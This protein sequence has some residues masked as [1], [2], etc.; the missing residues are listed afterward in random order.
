VN[1]VPCRSATRR[2]REPGRLRRT[3]TFGRLLGAVLIAGAAW[4][5]GWLTDS[6]DFALDPD[7]V[8]YAGLLRTPIDEVRAAI[9]IAAE[10]RPNVFGL[11]TA[12]MERRLAGLPTVAGARVAVRLPDGLDVTLVER[13]PVFQLALSGGTFLVGGDG[14]LL[15]PA[16]ASGASGDELLP[17]V[18]DNRAASRPLRP[19]DRLDEIDL[20]AITNLAAVG[21]AEL[22]SAA[23][24]LRLSIDDQLGFAIS[25]E[26]AGW[27]AVFGFYT[28]H[29]R[30]TAIIARQ[31]QCLRSLLADGEESVDTVYLE[32]TA[33][34]CG[35]FRPRET[36]S[37]EPS[38]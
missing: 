1:A 23:T 15:A 28:V 30:P 7:H 4:G 8:S 32:P 24:M 27:R 26:P 14:L 19:G 17:L 31:V 13:T 21:P 9:G 5:Y 11:R 2:R 33:D 16:A 25:A 3:I 34:R 36:P 18:I 29:L 22:G 6:P 35:T 38:G 10:G 20:A 37:P 12:A